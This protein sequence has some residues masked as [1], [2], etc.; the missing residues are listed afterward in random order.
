M[1]SNSNIAEGGVVG[2]L[3]GIHNGLAECLNKLNETFDATNNLDYAGD[4]VK[5][6]KHG[7][8]FESYVNTLLEDYQVEEDNG[9]NSF[10]VE[11]QDA[12]FGKLQQLIENSRT[13][14]LQEANMTGNLKPIVGLTLPLL[15]LYW[16]KNVFKDFIPTMVATQPD[17][18]I[19]IE[20][21]YIIDQN[22]EKHFLPEAFTDPKLDINAMARQALSK[23]PI[24]LP[25]VGFDLITKAGGS[26][27]N[28][29]QLSRLFFVDS[30]KYESK[31]AGSD[32]GTSPAEYKTIKTR[33]KADGGTGMFRYVIKGEDGK[34]VDILRGDV[35]FETGYI[36]VSSDLR[37]ITEITVDGSLS[38]ENHLRVM[39]VGWDKKVEEFYIPEGDHLST[40]LTEERMKDEN[41]IYNIDSTA[42]VVSQMNNVIAQKKDTQIRDFLIASRERIRGSKLFGGTTFDCRPPVSLQNIT[43][44]EWTRDGLKDTLDKLSYGLTQVL[45]NENVGISVIGHPLD[46]RLLDNV[47]WVYGKD[48]E[49]GGCKLDYTFGLYNNQRNFIIGSSQKMTKGSLMI[50]VTPLTEEHMTYKLFEY[51]FFISNDYRDPNNVRIPS[52]MASARY[53]ID[54]LIPIQGEIKILNNFI[55]ASDMYQNPA[56]STIGDEG[57]ANIN[58]W[59]DANIMQ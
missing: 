36:N 37:K 59:V 22:K 40:G 9:E 27:D 28:D 4:I 34:V 33:I 49:V 45:Q 12:N 25:N 52:V 26:R 46:I 38:N 42:K 31:A 23:D 13:A 1:F 44:I 5:I 39:S 19:G 7:P 51:Q 18:K 8:L 11:R 41:I 48:S 30:I 47:Q 32:P 53:L 3:N 16:I 15:K 55:S 10:L 56:G 43:H 50:I 14:I 21:E 6:L 29:D 2:G 54:E 58:G 20:R 24:T 35:D 57:N 17:V